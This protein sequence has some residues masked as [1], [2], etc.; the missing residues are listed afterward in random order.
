M[1][2][3]TLTIRSGKILTVFLFTIVFFTLSCSKSPVT[4]PNNTGGGSDTGSGSTQVP[5]STALDTTIA[6]GAGPNPAIKY[7]TSPAITLNGG[8][9]MVISGIIT[10][11]ITLNNCYNITIKNCK[12]GPNK[13]TGIQTDACSNIHIDSCYITQVSTGVYA[14]NSQGVSVTNCQALNMQGPFPKG[15][16]VQFDG[17][18]GGGNRV[19][20]NKFQN[21]FGQSLPEDAISMYKSSGLDSD[22]IQI[23]GNWI[24]GGGPSLTGGGIMLGD[25]GGSDI[26]AEG[27]KLVDPGQYGMAVSGGTNMTIVGN[28]IYAKAQSFTNVG[29][30]YWN[31]SGQPSSNVTIGGNRVNF[32]SG[33]YGINNTFL[34]PGNTTPTGWD[35]NILN[36][37]IGE[38]LLPANIITQ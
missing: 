16:F 28:S 6:P 1:K 23:F 18:S 35:T 38:S 37:A 7:T 31:Q 32:T 3:A 9:D 19:N 12:I 4:R 2:L 30:Y 13:L 24:R 10:P 36:A 22:P 29:L 25:Q 11:S 26:I 20:Y 15:A 5:L 14:L 17:C 27:N 8:H 33:K 34:A 21:I